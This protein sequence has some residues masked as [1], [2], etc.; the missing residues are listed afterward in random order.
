MTSAKRKNPNRAGTDARK[1]KDGRYET[2]ATL[3]TPTCRRRVSF[4][5]ATAEEA[6]NAKIQALADQARGVL[7]SDPGKLTTGVLPK[8]VR[9]HDLRH[10]AGTLALRQ[11][12]PLHTVS[13]ML[14][15]ADPAMTLRRYAHVLDDMHEDAARAMDDLF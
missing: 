12:I 1:R 4:Y 7:F 6:N 13:K 5:G 15:H 9:F 14:G 2:R 10:T 8:N 11:G 3:N